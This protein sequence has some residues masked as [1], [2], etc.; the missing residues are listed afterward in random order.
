MVNKGKRWFYWFEF[1][2]SGEWGEESMLGTFGGVGYILHWVIYEFGILMW[3]LLT[4]MNTRLYC[5]MYG[6]F[7]KNHRFVLLKGIL[8]NTNISDFPYFRVIIVTYEIICSNICIYIFLHYSSISDT[9]NFRTDKKFVRSQKP[10]Y[11]HPISLLQ[12]SFIEF[13]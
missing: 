13:T 6:V 2:S 9:K 7:S 8:Y 4:E 10:L 5:I 12:V 1:F 3:M 11:I